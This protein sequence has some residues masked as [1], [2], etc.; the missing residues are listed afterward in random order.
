VRTGLPRYNVF[1]W[2]MVAEGFVGE[3]L[4]MVGVRD[5]VITPHEPE[6]DGEVAGYPTYRVPFDL[7]WR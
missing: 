3:A 7:S 6:R 1:A 2:S 5:V 4:R